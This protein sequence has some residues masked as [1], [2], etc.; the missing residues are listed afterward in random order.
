MHY[1]RRNLLTASDLF[2]KNDLPNIQKL[3][4]HLQEEGRLEIDA[5]KQIVTRASYLLSLENN[6]LEING[7]IK[8]VGSLHGHFYD[9]LTIL[10]RPN[11]VPDEKYV[12]LG[13]YVHGGM[14]GFETVIYLFALKISYPSKIFMLRGNEDCRVIGDL[15]FAA[16]CVFK[17]NKQVYNFIMDALNY[18]PTAAVVNRKA[19][20]VHGG[21]SAKLKRL[22]EFSK[23]TRLGEPLPDSILS[24][25]LWTEPCLQQ[26]K[27][28]RDS[29]FSG[30]S[31][32]SATV[33][34]SSD[35]LIEFLEMNNL[36]VLIRS[37]QPLHEGVYLHKV[38]IQSNT[39]KDD[40]IN[41]TLKYRAPL[42][43]LCSAPN[44]QNYRNKGSYIVM[45]P[46]KINI[47]QFLWVPR[48]YCLPYFLNAFSWTLP[49]VTEKVLLMIADLVEIVEKKSQNKEISIEI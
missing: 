37:N 44:Y 36:Q 46:D 10:D 32:R 8:V 2:D 11:L 42:I 6:L 49:F 1:P 27:S 29:S 26:P 45:T 39:V 15:Q 21:I 17:Y 43:S 23:I 41:D 38:Q 35:Q 3:R 31:E 4:L 30:I 34:F 48:P 12:F 20:C 19:L 7:T 40:K 47:R 5:V 16:E 22:V 13:S 24:E 33:C 9:L 14:F 28:S 18:L 25:V